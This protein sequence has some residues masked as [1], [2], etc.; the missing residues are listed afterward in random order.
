MGVVHLAEDLR[1]GRRVAIKLLSPDLASDAETVARLAREA[2]ATAAI[3]HP[4]IARAIELGSESD[5]RPWLAMEYIEGRSLRDVLHAGALHPR[6]ALAIA[7]AV[8]SALS[9]AHGA[10]VIHRDIKPENVMLVAREGVE[11]GSRVDDEEQVKVLDFGIAKLD[12]RHGLKGPNT[13][14]GVVYGTPTYMAPEQ[15]RREPLDARADLYSLGI[16]LFEMISGS[17]PFD[18]DDLTVLARHLTL[19]PPPLSSPVAPFALTLALRSFVARLLA[20]KRDGRPASADAALTELDEALATIDSAGVES[21][22]LRTGA[23]RVPAGSLPAP[24]IS[25]VS[26]VK[27]SEPVAAKRSYIQ[28]KTAKL[29]AFA[30]SYGLTPQQLVFGFAVAFG[31]IVLVMV[32]AITAGG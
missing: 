6:R 23:T 14:A 20:K 5:G 2:Q 24:P 8:L 22:A 15:I 25:K 17:V 10:G 12:A 4:N 18:G 29:V 7:R 9:A 11:P 21:M 16:M 3:E 31:L 19:P 27:T 28:R 32:V 13:S 30:Q 26:L 1:D